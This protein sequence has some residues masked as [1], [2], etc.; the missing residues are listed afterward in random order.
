MNST[1]D[2]KKNEDTHEIGGPEENEI[3]NLKLYVLGSIIILTLL[4]N[5]LILFLVSSNI[6]LLSKFR[7]DYL[8][9]TGYL[10]L[11]VTC[12]HEFRIYDF[13][14]AKKF[15]FSFKGAAKCPLK[16]GAVRSNLGQIWS[17]Y[18]VVD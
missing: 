11:F 1:A 2:E 3:N 6:L 10:N 9:Q 15:L 5:F 18:V 12:F 16:G 14:F 13:F 7:S 8:L 4:G 17:T